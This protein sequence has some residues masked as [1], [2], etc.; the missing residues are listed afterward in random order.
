[1]RLAVVL[2]VT[3][4]GLWLAFNFFMAARD[5]TLKGHHDKA[6]RMMWGAAVT[7]TVM[8]AVAVIAYVIPA[9][10]TAAAGS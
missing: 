7:V 8:I 2:I 3:G 4:C 6:H 5:L 9:L 1:M 10:A